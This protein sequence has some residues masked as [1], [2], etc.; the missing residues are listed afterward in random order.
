M[1]RRLATTFWVASVLVSG[2]ALNARQ[3]PPGVENKYLETIRV[4][5]NVYVFKPKIDWSHG[6]G[7]A[8]IGPDGVFF[9]DTYIQFNYAE[10]AIRRLRQV[11]KLP[12]RYVLNTHWHNDHVTGNGVFKREFPNAQ[13]IAHDSTRAPLEQIV[14]PSV[15]SER[16]LI[17]QAITYLENEVKSGTTGRRRIPIV[18]TMTPFWAQLL[19][20]ARDYQ[21]EFHPARFANADITFSDSLTMRWGAQTLRLIH[22]AERGHSAGDVVVWIPENRT[23]ITGDLVVG[24]TPY[25][26]YY[27][28]PGMIKAIHALIAMNPAVIIPGHGVVQHDLS[29]I[30]L[31]ERAFTE[32]R[33]ASEAAIAAKVPE[34]RALDSI[35]LPDIDRAFVGDDPL[36]KWA[37]ETFFVRNLIHNTYK[38]TPGA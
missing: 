31:V 35:A 10:E 38:P 36:R 3:A 18:G 1:P 25:A 13:I 2:P 12:V 19:Q 23:L 20:N 4:S 32:Y 16:V 6:N 11:T 7:V 26:T 27:N 34:A 8:I 28:I 5:E 24:P 37:Y 33:K 21:K 9:I 30:Q 15:D 22:M 29:Y 14:K 17:P